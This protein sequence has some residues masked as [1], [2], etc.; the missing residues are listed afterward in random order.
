[1]N[2]RLIY[3]H[4]NWAC[5]GRNFQVKDIPID[6]ISDI[7]YSFFDLRENEQGFLVPTSSDP[8]ADTDKR[9]GPGESVSPPDSSIDPYFG[10]FGQFL[11]L[12]RQGKQFRFGL[13][14]GGWTFSKRFSSAVSSPAARTAFVEG[15]MCILNK[16][17][18]LFDRVDFDWEHISPA[19]CNYGATGNESRPEDA[20][21]FALFLQ[22]LRQRLDSANFGNVELSACVVGDPSK[23]NA[24]PLSAMC[25]YLTTL[26]LMTYDFASSSWGSC[27]AGHQTNLKSTSYAPLSIE[28]AVDYLIAKGVPASKLIIGV[29]FYSRGFANTAG[30]GLPCS[31]TSPDKSWEEGI[32]DYKQLPLAGAT[33]FWDD[34]A[35]ATYSYDPQK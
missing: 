14:I 19:G 8:W 22:L 29:A 7:N 33:E 12:K 6:Y 31:G 17:P 35:Q 13:S 3:Y 15:I 20:G 5:Y 2:K 28:K 30:L 21:N 26:N 34:A 24:L 1:M 4:T 18:G 27:L 25:Q 10:Q 9:Y 11:K 23:M 16:Y 32:V